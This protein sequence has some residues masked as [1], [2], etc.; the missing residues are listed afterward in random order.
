LAL[1][2]GAGP[3]ASANFGISIGIMATICAES[4]RIAAS[5]KRICPAMPD[6]Q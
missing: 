6:L 5:R 2:V 3:S 4:L 1:E